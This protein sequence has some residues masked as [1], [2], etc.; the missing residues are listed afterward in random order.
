MGIILNGF[1]LINK[2]LSNSEMRITI[3]ILSG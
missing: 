3:N 2:F 1:N